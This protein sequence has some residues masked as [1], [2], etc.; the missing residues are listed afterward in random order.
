MR[1]FPSVMSMPYTSPRSTM[2][3][4]SSGSITS[5]SASRTSV[6]VI[7]AIRPGSTFERNRF[8][9][10]HVVLQVHVT[11]E[12]ALEVRQFRQADAVRRAAIGRRDVAVGQLPNGTQLV[13]RLTMFAFHHSDRV[14][15]RPER[16]RE[17][18]ARLRGMFD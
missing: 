1:T 14:F 16:T 8:R 4:P 17:H 12:V 6:S 3:T 18:T 11:V 9:E 5:R 2:L 10:E 15:D 7:G 13:G